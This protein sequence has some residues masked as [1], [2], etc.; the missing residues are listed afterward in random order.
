[1]NSTENIEDRRHATLWAM[2]LEVKKL[3]GGYQHDSQLKCTGQKEACDSLVQ[4]FLTRA[5]QRK[6]AHPLSETLPVMSKS[7][8]E[9]KQIL[10]DITL[11]DNISLVVLPLCGYCRSGSPHMQLNGY[12]SNCRSSTPMPL[13]P[14]NHVPSCSPLENFKKDIQAIYDKVEGLN[15]T[16]FIR[17]RNEDPEKE[18]LK[19]PAGQ[20]LWDFIEYE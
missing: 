10:L 9:L 15:P 5:F 12:C 13:M 2:L 18:L 16:D 11:P 20:S 19:P 8:E 6:N 17:W 1:M 4:G 14:T 7:I 3:I